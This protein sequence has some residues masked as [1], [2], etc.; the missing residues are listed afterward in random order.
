MMYFYITIIFWILGHFFGAWM[1]YKEYMISGIK[2]NALDYFLFSSL[3]GFIFVMI[4]IGIYVF[5]GSL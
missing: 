2:P 1:T 5:I 3:W 4:L